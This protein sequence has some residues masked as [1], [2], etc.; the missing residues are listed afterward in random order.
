MKVALP[1]ATYGSCGAGSPT[2]STTTALPCASR[3]ISSPPEVVQVGCWAVARRHRSPLVALEEVGASG[4]LPARGRRL[5][6]ELARAE[7]VR[8]VRR[9]GQAVVPEAV[10]ALAAVLVVARVSR[11]P[12]RGSRSPAAGGAARGVRRVE[13]LVDLFDYD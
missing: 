4:G 7:P 2:K 12:E 6:R 10:G 1:S 3:A 11:G 8:Y 9:S 5:V 13:Q